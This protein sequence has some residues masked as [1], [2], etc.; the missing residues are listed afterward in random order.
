MIFWG[1]QELDL[2]EFRPGALSR[3]EFGTSLVMACMEIAAHMEDTGHEHP[4]DQCGLILEG[5]IEMFSGDERRVLA[6]NKAYFIPAGMRHGWKTVD[7][8]VRIPD[9]SPRQ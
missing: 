7:E 2:E 3:A 9:V 8:P 4:F 5:R 1:L 6:G